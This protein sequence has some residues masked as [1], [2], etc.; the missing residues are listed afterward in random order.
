MSNLTTKINQISIEINGKLNFFHISDGKI[1]LKF[2]HYVK[3]ENKYISHKIFD[4]I[5]LL[6]FIISFSKFPSHLT[7][8]MHCN[9]QTDHAVYRRSTGLNRLTTQQLFI[10][11]AWLFRF[12]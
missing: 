8:W 4:E 9:W 11:E 7:K 10:N 6:L 12:C 2:V 3:W 1:S 5:T